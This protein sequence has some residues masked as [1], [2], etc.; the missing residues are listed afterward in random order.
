MKKIVVLELSQ[1]ISVPTLQA[2][3]LS[4]DKDS[5]LD[6]TSLITSILLLDLVL[7]EE[8]KAAEMVMDGLMLLEE[9]EAEKSFL[10]RPAN[11]K[12]T[13]KSEP[14]ETEAAPKV[15]TLEAVELEE[16]SYCLPE[17]TLW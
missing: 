13:A 2:A 7:L 16:Q 9:A 1:E 3:G 4:Q 8:T 5:T 15:M 17:A 6:S 10:I 12:F 11:S 14:K